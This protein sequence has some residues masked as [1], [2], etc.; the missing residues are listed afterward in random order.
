MPATAKAGGKA[1]EGL[2]AMSETPTPYRDD[3]KNNSLLNKWMDDY[4]ARF[5]EDGDLWSVTGYALLDMVLKTMEKAGPNLT[6]DTLVKALDSTTF[7]RH[8]LGLPE[9]SFSPTKHLGGGAARIAQ[10]V[11]G[12]WVNISDYMKL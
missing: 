2:Y 3:P 7:P 5:N 9:Y 6:S 4:K 11:N 1:V 8:Y 10:I 12:R